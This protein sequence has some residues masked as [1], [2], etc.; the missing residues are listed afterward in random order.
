MAKT[1]KTYDMWCDVNSL[2]ES[3]IEKFKAIATA[4]QQSFLYEE[5]SNLAL[6]A[7]DEVIETLSSSVILNAV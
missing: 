4:K 1:Q 5:T 2:C 6:S 3:L 7:P